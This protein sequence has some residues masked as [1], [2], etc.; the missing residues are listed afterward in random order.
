MAVEL[1]L[2]RDNGE[3][4]TFNAY[5]VQHDNS[6]GP[7]KGGLRYHPQVDIDDVRRWV[8]ACPPPARLPAA[9]RGA[10]KP[11]KRPA[12]VVRS[13]IAA[14]EHPQGVQPASNMPNTGRRLRVWHRAPIILQD[15]L[16]RCLLLLLL[17]PRS[18][19]SLMTWKTAVMDIP[20]GGAKGGV[21]VDP[22]DLSERE[23]E[24]LT[25]KLVQVRA[26]VRVG[27]GS[28]GWVVFVGAA[29]AAA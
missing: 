27:G 25:R 24:I 2:L 3:V 16:C 5:R 15:S 26:C 20:F 11:G 18:L 6:R 28:G 14:A 9:G 22:K 8:L 4:A 7:F 29:A 17:R 10:W 12:R 23:L 21:S 1:A 13:S 19:A